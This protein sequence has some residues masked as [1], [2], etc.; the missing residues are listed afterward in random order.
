MSDWH[1]ADHQNLGMYRRFV[2]I[3]VVSAAIIAFAL[4]L[5]AMTLL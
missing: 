5:M 4:A 1:S 3:A 2:R